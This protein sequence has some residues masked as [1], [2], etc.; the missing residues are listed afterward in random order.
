MPCASSLNDG[1][2]PGT[3]HAA[4]GASRDAVTRMLCALLRGL[5]ARLRLREIGIAEMV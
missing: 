4:P 5:D 3:D 2:D 1:P